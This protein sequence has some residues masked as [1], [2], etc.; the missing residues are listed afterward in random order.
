VEQLANNFASA[1]L[2]PEATLTDF[3]SSSAE[4][5]I[6]RWLNATADKLQVTATALK[7]RLV[8]LKRLDAARARAISDEELRYNGHEAPT[9]EPPPLFSKSFMEVLGQ[10]IN[11]G[12]ISA[13]RAANLLDLTIEDLA[14]LFERHAV[15]APLDL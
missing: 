2:M 10:A 4:G 13:R 12:R 11:E 7:W 8:A 9:G 15:E 14:D 5:R 3:D 6:V 1:L